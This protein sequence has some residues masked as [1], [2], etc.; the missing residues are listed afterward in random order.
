M[1]NKLLFC[2]LMTNFLLPSDIHA[3]KEMSKS[4][5]DNQIVYKQGTYHAKKQKNTKRNLLFNNER[6][7]QFTSNAGMLVQFL[8]LATIIDQVILPINFSDSSLSHESY[9]DDLTIYQEDESSI[10]P[11]IS[12]NCISNQNKIGNPYRQEEMCESKVFIAIS[13]LPYALHLQEARKQNEIININFTLENNIKF[14]GHGF[15]SL[16]DFAKDIASNG[17]QTF[18]LEQDHQ[19]ETCSVLSIPNEVH[20]NPCSLSDSSLYSSEL[21]L[22]PEYCLAFAK[23]EIDRLSLKI[24]NKLKE[25]VSRSNGKPFGIIVGENHTKY[26]IFFLR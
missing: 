3:V 25:A 23:A 10:N 5:W 19:N 20:Y 18:S 7:L 2:L 8:L 12:S 21:Q 15:E 9:N 22:S 1:L 14:T 11:Y 16:T 17:L 24:A 13:A 4:K 6:P 26:Q